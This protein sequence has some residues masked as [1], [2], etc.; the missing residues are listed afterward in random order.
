MVPP[1]PSRPA[2]TAVFGST[3]LSSGQA[4]QICNDVNA[5]N[6]ATLEATHC[7][8]DN[9]AEALVG[10]DWYLQ[11]NPTATD[12]SLQ[13]E[14]SRV[15]TA[16][17]AYPCSVAASCDATTIASNSPYCTATVA[18]IV[19][20][21]DENDAI[22]RNLLAATPACD[23]VTVSNVTAY[24]APGGPLTTYSVISM[25]ASCLAL[26]SCNGIFTLSTPP[27]GT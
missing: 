2:S 7:A 9:D 22:T 10:A 1:A 5:A 20:C 24:Y 13:A 26:D 25:S 14:C 18:D 19:K 4:T 6:T 12:A 17:E 23:A 16:N 15:L 27:P 11:A 3:N 21:I 8:K